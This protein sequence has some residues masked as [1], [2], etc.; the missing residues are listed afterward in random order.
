MVILKP[1]D[2]M[3]LTC[4]ATGVP[5]PE[6]NWRLNWGH[7]PEKCTSTSINGTGTLTCENI[8]VSDQGAYSCEAL[9]I[10]GFVFAVP[11]A[12]LV[13]QTDLDSICPKGKFNSEA[14]RPEECIPCFCFG[15]ATECKSANLF[16]YHIP[17]PFDRHRVINVYIGQEIR[18]K[19]DA[20][21]DLIAVQPIGTD[22]VQIVSS[23]TNE[24]D[25]YDIPY[26]ALPEVYRREQLNSYGGYLK[27]SVRYSGNG[28]PNEAPAVILIG[29]NITL[30]YKGKSVLPNYETQESVRFF[31][32]YWFKKN[33]RYEEPARRADIM[34]ALQ[35]VDNI[36][37][38]YVS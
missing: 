23:Y 1:G 29:N 7:I 12:I 5:V 26:F 31:E 28:V 3:V 9:N 2:V 24:L 14:T 37:I 11:D 8:Q 34:V 4:T 19:G 21:R 20:D 30:V 18:V 13:V 22:G 36:L 35:N 16:T 15:V 6:I 10:E 32:G 27:Y 38:K 17:P 33:G 25:S